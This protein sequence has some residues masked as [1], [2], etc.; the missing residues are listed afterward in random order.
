V[1]NGHYQRDSFG[2]HYSE[3]VE[4]IYYLGDP[5]PPGGGSALVLYSW[6]SVGGSTSQGGI[7]K[8]F[9]ASN[10]RL[11]SIQEINWDT[12]FDAGRPT[13]SFDPATSTLV[14]RS[15]HYIPGDAHCCV[16]AV[17]IVIFRWNGAHF[18]KSGIRTELSEYG[19]REGKTLPNPLPR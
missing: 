6:F 13:E 1:T 16:S 14:I 19:R 9:T 15:A 12:H 3:E 18:V 17:D 2:D 7:A 8:V 4:S 10:G 11:R 5:E